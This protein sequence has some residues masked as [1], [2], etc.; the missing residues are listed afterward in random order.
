MK[1]V[2][3]GIA[4]A[5]AL[6]IL[7]SPASAQTVWRDGESL[8]RAASEWRADLMEMQREALR[9]VQAL[10]RQRQ[11][12]ASARRQDTRRQAQQRQISAW[13]EVTERV[14]RRLRLGRN[15]TFELQSFAGDVI[16]TGGRGDDVRIDAVK[17]VRHRMASAAR[18]VLPSVRIDVV[19]RGGN[20]ELRT[21]QPRRRDVWTSVDYVVNLPSGANVVLGVGSGN[22]R[23]T[24]VSGE[25]RADAD[26]GDLFATDVRR[27]RHLRTMRGDIEVADAEADELSA[28]TVEGDLRLRNLKG[29]VLDLNS[30]HGDVRLVDVQMNRAR[31]QSMAGNI[32][33][34]GPLARSGRY[35]FTTHSGNIRLT[36]SGGAGFDLEAHSFTGDIRTDYML[37]LF[38]ELPEALRRGAERRLRG[39]F[40]DAAAVLTARSFSGNIQIVRR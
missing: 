5:L 23:I 38:K 33:Y 8:L 37:T 14:S 1:T 19:E 22:V 25:L 35:E 28:H 21:D 32:E 18:S 2:G 7:A 39:T 24:N 26:D 15:G 34:A 13:P 4:A 11:P 16:I 17:R 20:I 3:R 29:R 9:Q 36:P 10:A 6:A 27:V 12:A 30:V 40:G 31:L